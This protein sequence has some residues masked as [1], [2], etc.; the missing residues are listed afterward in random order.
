MN[1]SIDVA[2]EGGGG[3]RGPPFC[4]RTGRGWDLRKT[5][6][7][8]GGGR[9]MIKKNVRA[10]ETLLDELF[11]FVG[12]FLSDNAPPRTIPEPKLRH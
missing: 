10:W 3:V 6:I 8:G 4:A 5:V 2:T 9:S 11:Q 1:S 7:V 12:G